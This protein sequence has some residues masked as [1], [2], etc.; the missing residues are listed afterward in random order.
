MAFDIVAVVAAGLTGA[1][2]WQ[3]EVDC[4]EERIRASKRGKPKVA[5]LG[6]A[7]ESEHVSHLG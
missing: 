6:T 1:R 5:C 7:N 3:G 4:H 2:L